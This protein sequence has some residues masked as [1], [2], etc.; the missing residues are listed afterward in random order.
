MLENI[1]GEIKNGHSRETVKSDNT[2]QR[3]TTQ[4]VLDI[5]ISKQTQIT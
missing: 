1:E 3:K 4:Y 2:R 5:T